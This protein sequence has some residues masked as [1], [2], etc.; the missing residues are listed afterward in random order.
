[1]Q[2]ASGAS[3]EPQVFYDAIQT[4]APINPGNSGGPLVNA[5]AQ[6]I[7]VNAA[8]DTLGGDPMTGAQGGSIGLGFAIPINQA[9][10][11]ATEL[12]RT[13]R[14][15]HAVLGA[16]ISTSFTGAGAQIAPAG[17]SRARSVTRRPSCARAT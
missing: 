12:I 4:D 1:V 7:G 3:G 17:A 16:N 11:V 2:P 14:A 6:V 5:Q 13:G 15:A 9:R 10:L 8:I